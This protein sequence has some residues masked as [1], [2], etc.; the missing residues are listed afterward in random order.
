MFKDVYSN[1]SLSKIDLKQASSIIKFLTDK[2]QLIQTLEGDQIQFCC[3]TVTKL[4]QSF[5]Q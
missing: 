4:A 2:I 5:K 1:T 3:Q